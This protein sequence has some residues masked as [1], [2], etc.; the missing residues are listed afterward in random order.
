MSKD[1]IINAGYQHRNFNYVNKLN[2]N[3]NLWI[4]QE[5]ARNFIKKEAITITKNGIY[6]APKGTLYNKVIVKVKR[7]DRA[8]ANSAAPSETEK[9]EITYTGR[10]VTVKQIRETVTFLSV[11]KITTPESGEKSITWVP[12][13]DASYYVDSEKI[14]IEDNGTYIA[15][16]D[17]LYGIIIV[18]VT[19]DEDDDQEDNLKLITKEITANGTYNAADDGAKGYSSVIVNVANAMQGNAL[20]HLDINNIMMWT[21]SD[22]ER[23]KLTDID[24]I[25]EVSVNVPKYSGEIYKIST[26]APKRDFFEAIAEQM[27]DVYVLGWF[28]DENKFQTKS[29]DKEALYNVLM[30]INM[31]DH[32]Y[33]YA[34][35]SWY[36]GDHRYYTKEP[37]PYISI[38]NIYHYDVIM[39]LP[40][41][42]RLDHYWYRNH[43]SVR[44][45]NWL[46]E[47]WIPCISVNDTKQICNVNSLKKYRLRINTTR[48]KSDEYIKN[49]PPNNTDF[50]LSATENLG[51]RLTIGRCVSSVLN[52][53]WFGIYLVRSS[54]DP[55]LPDDVNVIST[56]NSSSTFLYR[57]MDRCRIISN[58]NAVKGP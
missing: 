34:E 7:K 2:T 41:Y 22:N 28:D 53:G 20:K 46:Y 32:G 45:Y 47:A 43:V 38:I 29:I 39:E 5:E 12:E 18:H 9:P 51:G 17:T 6:V 58:I 26:F 56:S 3:G 25:E 14:T 11:S 15:D 16:P 50:T 19:K 36:T 24:V 13:E 55:G 10:D 35:L 1:I 8:K 57:H 4:P 49:E 30:E 44:G 27:S 21:K 31:P 37:D 33:F 48:D 54:I 40:I 52:R 42:V 23:Y